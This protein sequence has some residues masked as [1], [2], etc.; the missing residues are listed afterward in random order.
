MEFPQTY[1]TVACDRCKHRPVNPYEG[2]AVQTCQE[3]G[4]YPEIWEWKEFC[5]AK[6]VVRLNSRWVAN[7]RS[8]V[9]MTPVVGSEEG[10]MAFEEDLPPPPPTRF[11]RTWVI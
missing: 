7:D 1:P 9:Y 10:C 5:A 6:R 11:E 4:I 2:E 3:K 8:V